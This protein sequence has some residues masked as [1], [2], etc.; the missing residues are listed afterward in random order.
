MDERLGRV[1][2]V[3]GSQMTVTLEADERAE[4]AIRIGAMVTVRS[5]PLDVVGTIASIE[6]ENRG[7]SSHSVFIVDLLGEIVPSAEG[8]PDFRRGVS[9][10][11]VAGTPVRAAAE[12]DLT[13][14]YTRPAASN[15]SIGTLY[16][17]PRQP[18]FVMVDELLTKN[19]AVLGATGSGKSCGVTLIL[20]SIIADHPNSHVILLDP[21]NEYPKAFGALA[22]VLNVDNLQLPFWLLD[23][24]EAVGVLV[25]GGTAQEQEAQAII[26]KD[27]ITRARRRFAPNE[28][29]ASSITVDTP[30]PFKASDLLRFL[31]EAM[32][33]LDNPDTSAP[34]LRLRTRLDSL[35]HDRRFAF[36]FSDWLVTR[37]TLPEIVGRLLRIPVD[38]KP[39]TIIDLSGI[40]SEITD[41]LVSLTCRLTFD[42]ALWSEREQMPPVLLV[43]EEA[44]RYVPASPGQGFAAAGRAVTRLA[45]EG[46][47]Y[48]IALALITQLPSELSAQALSQCGTVFALRLGHY[49]DHRFMQAALPEAARGM[50]AVLPSLRTQEAIAFGEGVPLPI[51]VRFDD[52]PPER[53]PRSDS[54]KFSK[55]WQVNTAGLDFVKEGIRRWRQ[56]SRTPSKS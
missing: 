1:V 32:G 36:M 35:R 20:S 48:G 31:D 13:A 34:Y 7:P 23:F 12:R 38:G 45:R 26:L 14:I 39:L 6:A 54:A 9:H 49:L 43:C 44:H 4:E 51:H 10:Y 30:V 22:E 29:T 53:R 33:R 50:L 37:D 52:L 27:A 2:A 21:H 11:P 17:D 15:V 19:F 25:R 41:V 16:H 40:P 46:R 56:Q 3:A 42:F 5:G 47:K 28:R 24:E 55:A 18:A 8:W